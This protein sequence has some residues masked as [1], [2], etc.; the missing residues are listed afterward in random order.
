MV[1]SSDPENQ[2]MTE[3]P[4]ARPAPSTAISPDVMKVHVASGALLVSVI[5]PWCAVDFGS[6][7]GL[8]GLGEMFQGMMESV[9]QSASVKGLKLT[10]GKLAA[11]AAL[12]TAGATWGET[13]GRVQFDRGTLR[14]VALVAAG[15]GA[16]AALYAFFDISAPLRGSFG[17]YVAILA[18]GAAAFFSW[19]RFQAVRPAPAAG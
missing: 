12:I 18:A 13:S 6:G 5:L 9:G 2:P 14:L 15:L 19:Q 1:L 16:A 7:G 10:E 11:V 4:P 3:I 8:Q 17:L